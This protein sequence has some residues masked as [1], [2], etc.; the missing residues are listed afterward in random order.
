MARRVKIRRVVDGDSVEA[1]YGGL[2]GMMRRRP[3][4]VRLYAIDAPELAQ[5]NGAAARAHLQ[6]LVGGGGSL[7]IEVMDTDRYGRR[8]ALLYRGRGRRGRRNSVNAQ[9]VQAGMAY[10]YGRYGGQ[11]LGLDRAEAEARRQRRGVW[12]RGGKGQRPWDYRSD[13]RNREGRRGGRWRWRRRLIV[14]AAV[15][16]ILLVG[17]AYA[18]GVGEIGRQ[19]GAGLSG[20]LR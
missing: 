2:L 17:I 16:V 9:M 8:V 14:A 20:L 1:Q 5:P 13:R 10:W 12:R 18:A 15:T 6:S 3:F 11:E 4:P 19:I 7:R